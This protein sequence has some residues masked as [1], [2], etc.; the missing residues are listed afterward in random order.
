VW[1]TALVNP[2]GESPVTIMYSDLIADLL[3]H[4]RHVRNWNADTVATKL[5]L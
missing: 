5:L 2:I 4:L 3:G 1:G